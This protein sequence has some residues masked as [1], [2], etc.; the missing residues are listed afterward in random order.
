[1]AVDLAFQ[2]RFIRDTELANYGLPPADEQANIMSLVDSAS[3]LLDE[4]CGRKDADG[5]GSLVYS[6]YH[7][8]LQVTSGR[9]ILRLSYRPLA[10][11]TQ[12][13]INQLVA[14]G[15]NGEKPGY[16]SGLDANTTYLTGSSTLS[17]IV[18][19][20]GR[21][22]YGRRGDRFG[23]PDANYGMSILQIQT[24]FGGPPQW[25][26]ID[27]SSISFN[28]Q[29]G[30]IWVPAGLMLTNYT[31]IDIRY[32]SGFHPDRIPPT[33]KQATAALIRNLLARGGGTTGIKAITGA[34]HI[35]L[36]FSDELI[37][38]TIDKMLT[39]YKTVIAI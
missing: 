19:A 9:N 33:I 35:G 13:T 39:S 17:P 18:A 15:D 38:P 2:P 11:I 37:D 32:N 6:T 21:Y 16:N 20:S 30:E 22:G 3:I 5:N 4:H 10:A 7:E 24:L 27:V 8:I 1:M 36:A 25:A 26:A 23:Y 12:D 31:E 29:S 34:G 14:S 28:P